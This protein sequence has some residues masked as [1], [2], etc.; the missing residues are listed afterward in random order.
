MLRKSP[1][2][3]VAGKDRLVAEVFVEAHAM[4]AAA[5]GAA[6]PGYA[7]SL[8]QPKPTGA[9]SERCDNADDLM[10]GNDGKALG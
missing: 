4:N 1:V 5:A 2:T 3:V 7:D 6:K 9:R 10:P 8:A